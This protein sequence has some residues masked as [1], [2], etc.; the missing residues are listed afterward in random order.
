MQLE[1]RA[2]DAASELGTPTCEVWLSGN[3][4]DTDGNFI[5]METDVSP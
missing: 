3:C 2:L 1:S 5:F 4:S